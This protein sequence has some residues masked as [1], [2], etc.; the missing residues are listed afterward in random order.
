[1]TTTATTTRRTGSAVRRAFTPAVQ[2]YRDLL[3]RENNLADV[4]DYLRLFDRV[5]I[6]TVAA[7]G[8]RL[9]ARDARG[10]AAQAVTLEVCRG[11][12]DESVGHRVGVELFAAATV[13]GEYLRLPAADPL[14]AD[15]AAALGRDPRH[16]LRTPVELLMI[17]YRLLLTTPDQAST[18]R[19]DQHR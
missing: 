9:A 6:T 3:R 17:A 8:V 2:R 16:E 7:R 1:M 11:A 12:G 10:S 15:L 4:P 14:V 13:L 5:D 19:P 18:K